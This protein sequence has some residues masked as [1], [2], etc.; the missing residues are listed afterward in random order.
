MGGITMM[1]L[2]VMYPY[3]PDM[4]FDETYYRETHMPLLHQRWDDLGLSEARVIRGI[5]AGDGSSP[6]Y[7]LMALLSFPDM[8]SLQHA[9]STHG[10]E[11]FDDIPNFTGA[12]P[13]VQVSEIVTACHTTNSDT[14]PTS[15]WTDIEP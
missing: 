8:E 4:R 13:I 14:Y 1:L 9:V 6:Q 11:L 7:R 15:G 12:S 3:S 5:A 10:K 2:I